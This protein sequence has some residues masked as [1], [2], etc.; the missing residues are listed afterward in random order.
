M[1]PWQVARTVIGKPVAQIDASG[2]SLA[3]DDLVTQVVDPLMQAN[4]AELREVMGWQYAQ[5][6]AEQG[7]WHSAL[8][9]TQ[10]LGKVAREI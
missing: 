7:V 9:E 6:A 1:S 5:D 10:G 4:G 8:A 2:G 3:V